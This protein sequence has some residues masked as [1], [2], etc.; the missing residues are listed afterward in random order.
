M[1]DV[2]TRVEDARAVVD[3]WDTVFTALAAEP[4]RQL[5]VSLLDAPSGKPVSL[6]GG[7]R[8]P[9]LPTVPERFRLRL[10]HEHLP[11]LAENGFVDWEDDPLVA[12]R[13]PRFDEIAIVMDSL[14]GAAGEI[15]DSLVI[16]CQRL[17][18]ERQTGLDR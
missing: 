11:M 2:G 17:E 14:Q 9:N 10:I 12:S 18:Q 16:G 3:R 4:R 5:V 7:A 13:G 1:T 6:P 8:N 15:P